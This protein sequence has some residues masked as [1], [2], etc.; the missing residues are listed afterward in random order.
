MTIT[1]HVSYAE[2]ANASPLLS[3][4]EVSPAIVPYGYR[5]PEVNESG[6][7]TQ[8]KPIDGYV[9]EPTDEPLAAWRMQELVTG[10][11]IV[12]LDTS[13]GRLIIRK[14][15][16]NLAKNRL[17]PNHFCCFSVR[18]V[19]NTAH[20]GMNFDRVKDRRYLLEAI[21]S[22]GL[23]FGKVDKDITF[24]TKIIRDIE[25][26][27]SALWFIDAVVPA[28]EYLHSTFEEIDKK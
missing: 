6:I 2:A 20:I 1:E 23:M 7:F 21:G 24:E 5:V 28:S 9:V 26:R 4:L 25:S 8:S 3:V 12:V 14:F 10:K 11:G 17:D 22:Q 18:P 19:Y 13:F 15:T 16:P 27:M